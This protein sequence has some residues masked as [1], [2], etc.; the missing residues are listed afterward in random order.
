MSHDQRGGSSC[1]INWYFWEINWIKEI[2]YDTD[3][4][5]S[6][7]LI[8]EIFKIAALLLCHFLGM[9]RFGD[10]VLTRKKLLMICT[11]IL[12]QFGSLFL[13]FFFW[14]RQFGSLLIPW[15]AGLGT[16]LKRSLRHSSQEAVLA[17]LAS[18]RNEW[19]ISFYLLM[20][21]R[22]SE[23]FF[24]FFC[25]MFVRYLKV[26]NAFRIRTWW[27]QMQLNSTTIWVTGFEI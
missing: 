26:K 6:S 5:N 2:S 16:L 4:N 11:F 9:N 13:L 7:F 22:N 27:I 10:C 15:A 14:S 8:S 20:L 18:K 1:H 3:K 17:T 23:Q 21:Q 24:F 12:I 25:G 19:Y